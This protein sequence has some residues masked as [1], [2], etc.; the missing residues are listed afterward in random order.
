VLSRENAVT[1][2]F[3]ALAAVALFAV[4][5]LTTPPTWVGAAVLLGVGVV[6]PTL[7]NEYLDRQEGST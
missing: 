6:I 2:S 3:I 4:N 1:V 5:E 7:V